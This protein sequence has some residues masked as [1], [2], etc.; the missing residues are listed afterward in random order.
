MTHCPGLVI[1]DYG[2]QYTLLIARKL[3]EMNVFTEIVPASD[4]SFP[5][6]IEVHG[7]ILSGGPASVGESA[8]KLPQYVVDSQLPLLGV[9]FGMQLIA[10]H[11]GG[12]VE[13]S[14]KSQYGRAQLKLTEVNSKKSTDL[15]FGLDAESTVW[16]SHGDSVVQVPADFEAVGYA[17]QT[18]AAMTHKTKAIFGLQFHP[19]VQHTKQGEDLLRNFVAISECPQMWDG[20]GMLEEACECVLQD[21]KAGR[22]LLALSGGVDSTVAAMVVKK[23]LPR[24]QYEMVLIDHGM[25]R[26]NEVADIRQ[27]FAQLGLPVTVL[28]REELFLSRLKG[29]SDPET[30]RKIIGKAFIDCFEEFT[31]QH[32]PFS[33]L[34]QGTLYPDVIESAGTHGLAKT[35]KSHHNVGGLPERLKLQLLEPFRLLFKDEVRLVGRQLEIPQALVGRHPFPGPGLAVR[36][37]GE[38]TKEKIGYLQEAD[39][40]FIGALRESGYYDQTWQALVVLLP[41]KSVGVMGDQ[42]TYAYTCVLRAV[43]STDGMTANVTDLPLSFLTQVSDKIVNQVSGINRVLFDIT[44]KPPAT[45]EWE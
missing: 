17:D 27:S 32:G 19:E 16:M 37:P 33:L 7:V 12:K 35:I 45:I 42:R 14:S 22:V 38:V 15:F 21:A 28:N 36:I 10:E 20:K 1:V 11:F 2:S 24:D 8:H 4:Q 39:A 30:K 31:Q 13:A 34:C 26:K 44:S 6:S 18:I 43:C 23:C 5:D 41:V 40:I 25:M 29:V 9:C 3:R